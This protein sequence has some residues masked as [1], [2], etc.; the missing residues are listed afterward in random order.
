MTIQCEKVGP[1][2]F[3]HARWCFRAHEI[4]RA[5]PGRIF[6]V[7]EDAGS[8]PRWAFPITRVEWTSPLPIEV[9]STRTV[10]MMGG[11]TGYEE[12]I[13]WERGR[14]MAFRFD[15]VSRPGVA[16]FAEDYLVTD[17]GDGRCLV[18][19]TMA[20]VPEGAGANLMPL[21]SPLMGAGL[22]HMLRSFRRYVESDPVLPAC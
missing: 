20:M 3:E 13:V 16:A 10:D 17:L 9:G 12:F 5:T 11:L 18:E 8:W 15:E 1:E 2:F 6:D 4:V 22:R 7:F 21:T 19:W 14:R